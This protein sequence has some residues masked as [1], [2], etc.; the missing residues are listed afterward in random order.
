MPHAL[1]LEAFCSQRDNLPVM[2]T[3]RVHVHKIQTRMPRRPVG[4][5][6][7]VSERHDVSINRA[8]LNELVACIHDFLLEIHEL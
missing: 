3:N 5:L 8:R 4:S 1:L 7:T 2:D 6:R